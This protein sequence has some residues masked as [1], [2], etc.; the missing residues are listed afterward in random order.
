MNGIPLEEPTLIAIREILGI[1]SQSINRRVV[2]DN[3]LNISKESLEVY[4]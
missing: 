3:P 1:S 4:N 2:D